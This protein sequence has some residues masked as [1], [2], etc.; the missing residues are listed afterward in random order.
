MKALWIGIAV[1]LLAPLCA[2]DPATHGR[3][4]ALLDEAE[5]QFNRPAGYVDRP[6]AST[7]VLDYEHA[8]RSEDGL[9]EIRLAVRPIKRL[10][11]DYDDPHGSTPDPNHIFPLVFESLASRRAG[12]R[13]APSNE[14]PP[15]Q[16]RAKFNA[17]WAAAAVFDTVDAFATEYRQGLL[18]AIHRN[19]VSDAYLVFLFDDYAQAR[20]RLNA[21]LST[22]MFKPEAAKPAAAESAAEPAGEGAG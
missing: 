18:V 13:H 14:Y 15:D 11:I 17:D 20:E 12:G 1:L 22:L 8:L 4:D 21:A 6:P 7:P 19:R 3:F 5:L 10:Q 9:L 2:A 16:A